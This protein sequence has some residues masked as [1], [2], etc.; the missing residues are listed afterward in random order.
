MFRESTV[1][2]ING[3]GELFRFVTPI[4]IASS[5]Y[6]GSMA[7][8]NI[9]VSITKLESHFTNHLSDHKTVELMI[10]K[11]LSTIEILSYGFQHY[12]NEKRK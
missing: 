8:N 2:R 12:L 1:K 5:A 7:L 6:F 10:E 11:R 4:L 9:K 3:W